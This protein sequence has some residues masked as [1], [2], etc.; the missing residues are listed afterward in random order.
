MVAVACLIFHHLDLLSR[1]PPTCN[2]LNL[3]SAI[4]LYRLETGHLPATL[5]DL[6][7]SDGHG[8]YPVPPDRWAHPVKYT[9]LEDGRYEIRSFGPDGQAGTEDDIVWRPGGGTQQTNAPASS[10]AE[11]SKR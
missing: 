3:N 5:E 1:P 10:S 8:Y 11:D 7:R 9:V 6:V 2:F 4:G